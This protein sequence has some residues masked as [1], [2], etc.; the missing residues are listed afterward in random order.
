LIVRIVVSLLF[1]LL[2]LSACDAPQPQV[3]AA[4][5]PGPEGRTG[6]ATG[7]G[8]IQFLGGDG[9]SLAQAILIHG[10]QGEV[11]GVPSEYDWLAANRPGWK[12]MGQSLI[13]GGSRKFDVLHITNGSQQADVYFDITEYFGKF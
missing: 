2:S 11:D 8:Q 4:M 9:S 5:T 12:A 7:S 10:A 1:V 6:T 13:S 3:I